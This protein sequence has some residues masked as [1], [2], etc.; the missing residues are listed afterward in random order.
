MA[1][2]ILA[3]C[4]FPWLF[5]LGPH[6]LPSYT[7]RLTGHMIICPGSYGIT[8]LFSPL[9]RSSMYLWSGE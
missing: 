9:P 2:I 1:L 8:G 3:K 4:T 5:D 6:N 7:P